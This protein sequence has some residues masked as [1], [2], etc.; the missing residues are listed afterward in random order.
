[1]ESVATGE[2]KL[3]PS[4]AGK[5]M[6][7]T[8][9]PFQVLTGSPTP[10]AI[11][12][13]TASPTS[14]RSESRK[15]K[16]SVES[17]VAVDALRAAKIGRTSEA[18]E[19]V[20]DA[21][22]AVILLDDDSMP[23]VGADDEGS[24]S[25]DLVDVRKDGKLV[26]VATP[27][28]GGSES[29]EGSSDRKI[30]IKLPM[31]SK[32]RK[33]AGGKEGSEKKKK[34]V[35]EKKRGKKEGKGKVEPA[36]DAEPIAIDDSDLS[37]DEKEEP[38]KAKEADEQP[39]VEEKAK[40]TSKKVE[41]VVE[42]PLKD[43]ENV[44]ND[45][46]K[47][48]D[49]EAV[50]ETPAKTEEKV[51][52]M[53]SETAKSEVT[54][55]R[56]RPRQSRASKEESEKKKSPK[57][58]RSSVKAAKTTKQ[59]ETSEEVK[60]AVEEVA[61]SK[62]EPT[63]T[64][65]EDVSTEE[66]KE[67]EP[68]KTSDVE[69]SDKSKEQPE[70]PSKTS[71][72]EAKPEKETKVVKEAKTPSVTDSNGKRTRYSR[73]ASAKKPEGAEETPNK[74]TTPEDK[75]PPSAKGALDKFFAKVQNG[76]EDKPKIV[77][78]VEPSEEPM[79]VDS[80]ESRN[81]TIASICL[82][83]S[84]DGEN[85]AD[86]EENAYMLCTPNSKDRTALSGAADNR[87]LTPKQMARKMEAEKRLAL[88][89]QEL[90]DRKRKKEEEREA[91]QKEREEQE[92]LRK[93][94][95]EDKEEQKR[96]EREEKE[97]QKRKEREE[98]EE[99]KRK[100]KEEKDEQKRKEREEKEKKRQAELDAKNEE[101]RKKDEQKEEERR[102]K[103]E[104]KEA[105][106][107]R[108][109]K[110][111][112]AFQSFFVKKAGG[113]SKHS[114]DENSMESSGE[115]HQFLPPQQQAFMP[116][117][118][119][120]DMRL[121]PTCRVTLP[122]D[123]KLKLED[124]LRKSSDEQGKQA[125]VVERSE[126]YLGQLKS[127][128]YQAGTMDRTWIAE[129]E[130]ADGA[131]DDVMIVDDDVC[132]QI[133]EDRTAVP[134]KRYR[135]KYF[136]FE[137][138]RRPPYRGTWRKKSANIRPRKPFA[139]D[140][141]F[142]DYEVDSDD[143]W[144]EEEPGESLHGSDDEKDVDK[145]EEDYEVDND[146]F[147]PH[148]H[149]SDEELQAEDDVADDNSPEAQKAK[150]KI[151]QQEFAAEMKKKTE[152]IK[153]RL[154]GCLW[155]NGGSGN[156]RSEC[157]AVIWEILKARAMLFDPEEPISFTTVR[158]SEPDSN[159][160]SPAKPGEASSATERV[161]KAKMV[162]LVDEGVREL[163]MM[164]HGC[165]QNRS[166]L[167]KEFLAYWGKRRDDGEKVPQFA[168][169]SIRTKIL[170]IS[171]WRPCP[172][173]GPMQNKMCWYVN[174]EALVRYELTDLKV[175][176]GWDYILK[177]IVKSKKERKEK[178]KDAEGGGEGE[179]GGEEKKTPP[180]KKKSKEVVNGEE[181]EKKERQSSTP[182]SSSKAKPAA[183]AAITKFTKKLSEDEKRKQ[184]AK[185]RKKSIT[186]GAEATTTP[187]QKPKAKPSSSTKK[188]PT[189]A[190]S[191]STDSQQQPKKRVQLLMSVPRGQS[192][193]QATKNNLISQFLAKKPADA[194]SSST[195][196]SNKGL[197]RMDVDEIVVLDD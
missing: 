60:A 179:E 23:G 129:E 91:K 25:R 192:I 82:N 197:E 89:Q 28:E 171:S 128:Q 193:P 174:K 160:S 32:K 1:M 102:K 52:E 121:A 36:A 112:Q 27:K 170:E 152:K 126:L 67:K 54:P 81:N 95:K 26:K 110:T 2:S 124:L 151:M 177:P 43:Q 131:E 137:E 58:R 29:G 56:G 38:E 109:Q 85:T 98:K 71:E 41:E 46:S 22:D 84:D 163:I 143:E 188:T 9:L 138:N 147:V 30:R 15:R 20:K 166:F 159:S 31:A 51:E 92:R 12:P 75:K 35:K 49:K 70:E 87:K 66:V 185:E 127:A 195:S 178:D 145:E 65:E 135:A 39:V 68:A 13:A 99:Q 14:L 47:T 6:K 187:N 106:E 50:E 132:H 139:Q 164:I 111:A 182:S 167:V 168:P 21:V 157:S 69:S 63:K 45:E 96:K 158:S 162:K 173:E 165:G 116:F 7:Q 155:E 44:K 108:K 169:D 196:G 183:G 144:E 4:A 134:S 11:A 133:E 5:K 88:K 154:I 76:P 77:V 90:E 34:V 194:G 181:K 55:R 33:S 3:S 117:C 8:R 140:T 64:V 10:A 118:V 184:F 42:E 103:E 73:A 123:R 148:G 136:L 190:A 48:E 153:P 149:L 37:E 141:K 156:E 113:G 114:D 175:P 105:E 19:N 120:G 17:T 57:P 172:E 72:V 146:F 74:E 115:D 18:K 79:E 83:D 94:E 191:S 176:T 130:D 101:K 150:L 78:T 62:A 59:Q 97:E 122:K 104:E 100:E 125:V 107:K 180:K 189:A 119:K 93:K 24:N 86:A 161:P 53:P 80:A 142:F 61:E 16:P 40:E 186:N